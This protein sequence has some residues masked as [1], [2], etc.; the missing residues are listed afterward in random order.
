MAQ[1]FFFLLNKEEYFKYTHP[2]RE[3]NKSMHPPKEQHYND[4]DFILG[5]VKYKYGLVKWNDKK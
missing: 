5:K 2:I 3:L 1:M 4:V